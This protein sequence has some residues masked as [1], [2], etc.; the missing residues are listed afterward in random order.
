MLQAGMLVVKLAYSTTPIDAQV[1]CSLAARAQA[2]AELDEFN[3]CTADDNDNFAS[4]WASLSLASHASP[5]S[6]SS[7]L[8][9]LSRKKESEG[10]GGQDSE[11]RVESQSNP[12]KDGWS[13]CLRDIVKSMRISYTLN[14]AACYL[15]LKDF[16]MAVECCDE[17][18]GYDDK[19]VK[20]LFRRGEAYRNLGKLRAAKVDLVSAAKLASEIVDVSKR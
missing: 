11:S 17:V 13:E 7:S 2:R 5:S 10:I 6:T 16:S 3:P 1:Y 4:Y 9:S 12:S 19:C 20:A 8:S 18:L 15:K 14:Q